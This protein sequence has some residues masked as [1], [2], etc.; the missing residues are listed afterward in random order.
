MR[1]YTTHEAE[2]LLGLAYGVVQVYALRYG[3]GHKVER[4]WRLTDTDLDVIR[5]RMGKTR[6]TS[7]VRKNR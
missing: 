6:Y 1:E 7:P 2:R 3:V 5:A 4:H